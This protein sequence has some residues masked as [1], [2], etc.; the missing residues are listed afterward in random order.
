[1]CVMSKLTTQDL[2]ARFA[3]QEATIRRQ[4][5]LAAIAEDPEAVLE[6]SFSSMQQA[7]GED[8][9]EITVRE[10][11]DVLRPLEVSVYSGNG[12]RLVGEARE[13]AKQQI[14]ELLE[15]YGGL[16]CREIAGSIKLSSRRTHAILKQLRDDDRIRSKGNKVATV[17][18]LPA[19]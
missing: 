2:E 8:G 17:Y 15:H 11:V 4:A 13:E 1:M 7:F 19:K 5:K 9:E 3:A 18:F 6:M 10:L 14:L 12:T 16:S